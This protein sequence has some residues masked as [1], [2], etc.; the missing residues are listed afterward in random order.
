[1]RIVMR[2][3]VAMML[4]S[5]VTARADESLG[6]ILMEGFKTLEEVRS[7]AE[8]QSTTHPYYHSTGK[9]H[10]VFSGAITNST[11]QGMVIFSDD[12]CR[13]TVDGKTVH[14]LYDKPQALEKTNQSFHVLPIILPPVDF[15]NIPPHNI[16]VEYSNLYYGTRRVDIDGCTLFQFDMS[17]TF[18]ND[19]LNSGY[20]DWTEF[21]SGGDRQIWLSVPQ[22]GT[23]SLTVLISPADI[24]PKITFDTDNP[25]I[26]TVSPTS[27]TSTSQLLK[28]TGAASGEDI[29]NTLVNVKYD[30]IK[31]A[32]FHADVLPKRSGLPVKIYYVTEA[33]MTN[34]PP[35]SLLA[36]FAVSDALARVYNK[37]ANVYFDVAQPVNQTVAYDINTNTN[38]DIVDVPIGGG[39]DPGPEEMAIFTACGSVDTFRKVIYIFGVNRLNVPTGGETL[40]IGR[41]YQRWACLGL[42]DWFD[43]DLDSAE[44]NQIIAHEVGHT[45]NLDDIITPTDRLMYNLPGAKGRRLIRE[46]WRKANMT[47]KDILVP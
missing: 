24:L 10:I 15:T 32:S 40:G 22:G 1:M 6:R 8:S 9:E 18:T 29:T 21:Q 46:E 17:V 19:D 35:P 39:F 20:D 34:S 33:A 14:D 13:V 30:S 38:L 7:A 41:T 5:V 23:N 25:N 37:Q 43:L 42:S 3:F 4:L 28:V 36:A 47:A 2:F 16:K 45:L 11:P 12:G 27:T 44:R 31:I 26:A